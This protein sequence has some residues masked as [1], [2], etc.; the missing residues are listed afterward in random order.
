MLDR[1]PRQGS[2]WD[3]EWIEPLIDKGSF[4]WHFRRIV[5][6]MISDE[7]FQWGYDLDRGRKA[8]PPSLIACA[9]ILQ[10]KY[11]LSDREMERQI[12][13]NLA[14]KYALG[15]PM[16][17]KGFDHT[18]LCKFRL[19]SAKEHVARLCFEKFRDALVDAG[20]VRKGEV[21]IIDTTH[22]VA[23]IAIPHTAKL[24]RMGIN[25]ALKALSRHGETKSSRA[26]K[27]LKLDM[28]LRTGDGNDERQKLRELVYAS[29]DLLEYLEANGEINL[30]GVKEKAEE[31]RRIVSENIA[32]RDNGGEKIFEEEK[33]DGGRDR[34]VSP[35]DPDARHGRKSSNQKFTG[36]KAQIIES[37]NEFITAIDGMEGNKHDSHLA[38]EMLEVMDNYG[39][40]PD[41]VVGDR[42][43]GNELLKKRLSDIGVELVTPPR[44]GEGGAN[45]HFKNSEFKYIPP[46]GEQSA[47]LIC[48]AGETAN[49]P[50]K[51]YGG[52]RFIFENCENCSLKAK[53]TSAKRR[54][55]EIT[56]A[57]F[58][59]KEVEEFSRTET[60][61]NL[62]K[63]R[64]KIERKNGQIKTQIGF[65]RC[66]YR[67]L[68]KFRLQCFFT[69]LVANIQRLIVL[70]PHAPPGELLRSA[71]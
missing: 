48:P 57:Y 12:R 67:G 1:S 4:E 18:T 54:Q 20:L 3:S 71:G 27:D 34:L 58:Y 28:A 55:V 45:G 13:F 24:V 63:A 16:D 37:E 14:T 39:I 36:Y 69:A 43:Y 50:C 40:K 42:A 15:L 70:L 52:E 44:E 49:D 32:E 8:I 65:R 11:D 61:K 25:G 10:R 7:D 51:V 6:P 60:Y 2:F 47:R 30:A 5:R 22:V 38:S 59:R 66:S 53:C 17:D 29:R 64:G 31:L 46:E 41:I 62:M 9:L 26:F 19:M 35:V 56:S 68:V 23:D 21:A 33:K